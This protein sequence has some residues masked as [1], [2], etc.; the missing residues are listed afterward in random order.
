[1]KIWSNQAK[2][3][4]KCNTS[5]ACKTKI[6]ASKRKSKQ[7]L[8]WSKHTLQ[9]CS[10]FF[11]WFFPDF[12][13]LLYYSYCCF[14]FWFKMFVFHWAKRNFVGHPSTSYSTVCILYYYG[15]M[16]W[17]VISDQEARIN[18]LYIGIET[19]KTDLLV[20]RK[21]K[22]WPPYCASIVGTLGSVTRFSTPIYFMIWTHL[23][24][25]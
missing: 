25:W 12:L 14:C 1:M 4:V 13:F 6:Y 2:L 15:K 10:H 17:S 19:S 3:Q 18:S 24:P 9:N 16:G 5:I 22:C 21:G 11:A 23:G 20:W 7:N 8:A